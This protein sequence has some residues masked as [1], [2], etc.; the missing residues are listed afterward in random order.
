MTVSLEHKQKVEELRRKYGHILS[1]H[2]FD[3]LYLWRKNMGIQLWI[4]DDLFSAKCTFKGENAWM[5]P[6][7]N[8]ADK[9][10]FIEERKNTPDFKLCYMGETDTAFLEREFPGVFCVGRDKN[11]DEYIYSIEEHRALKGKNYANV[12]TQ[13]NKIQRE[14][15]LETRFINKDN[16]ELALSVLEECEQKKQN[17]MP[18]IDAGVAKETLMLK[19]ELEVRGMLTYVDGQPMAVCAGFPLT[20][21]TFDVCLAKS[22]GTL[23]GL[24]YYSKREF[25]ISLP[26]HFKYINLEE[27]LGAKGLATMKNILYPVKKNKIWEATVIG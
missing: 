5:F 24:G 23:N 12:R 7:G 3:S 17:E 2:A 25:F 19:Q 11:S 27:D 9:K 18:L 20:E 14:H 15:F 16:L 22:I 10:R 6:C 4:E 13:Y 8:E 26:D 1:S 21:D